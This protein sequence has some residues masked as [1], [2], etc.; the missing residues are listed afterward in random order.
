MQKV[1]IKNYPMV[2]PT[3]V[4][5][6][7]ADVEGKPNYAAVGAFGVVCM[8]P[9]FY[10]SLKDTH[11][12]TLGV[13]EKGYFSVNLTS[14]E[15]VKKTDYCGMVTGKTTD[16]SNIFTSFYDED[17]KAPMISDSPMNYLCKVIQSVPICG[18]EVFFGEIVL[19]YINEQ[20]LT[21]GKPDPLKI[22]PVFLMSPGYFSIGQFLGSIFSEG[23]AVSGN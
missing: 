18:F 1:K 3:P 9:I 5:L 13:R 2:N 23:K 17:R 7:G 19:T 6:V 10:I 22:A 16:K 20:C 15:M 21:D 11:Y 8:E 4:V 14:P 12:T